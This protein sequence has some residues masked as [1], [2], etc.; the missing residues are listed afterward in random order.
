MRVKIFFVVGFVHFTGYSL[1]QAPLREWI[2][3]CTTVFTH[4]SRAALLHLRG[5]L[6]CMHASSGKFDMHAENLSVLEGSY[7]GG[8][9]GGK[10]CQ[11]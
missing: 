5:A 6:T 1:L 8:E 9:E 10:E 2:F 4:A 11:F 7:G 3:A